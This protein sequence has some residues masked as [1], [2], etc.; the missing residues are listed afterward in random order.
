MDDEA[1]ADLLIDARL[2]TPCAHPRARCEVS[3]ELHRWYLDVVHSGG[4]APVSRRVLS[5][6]TLVETRREAQVADLSLWLAR[7]HALTSPHP[8]LADSDGGRGACRAPG[9]AGASAHTPP[10]DAV[11]GDDRLGDDR[12]R[13][14]VA[15]SPRD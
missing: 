13:D 1:I 9:D 6:Q 8:D 12:A 5:W 11:A 10:G 7:L 3:I 4:T 15:S 14:R 2:S